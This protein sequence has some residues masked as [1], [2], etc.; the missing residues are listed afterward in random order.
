MCSGKKDEILLYILGS[1]F[2]GYS[3][4]ECGKI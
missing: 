3:R 4:K 2:A 1:K